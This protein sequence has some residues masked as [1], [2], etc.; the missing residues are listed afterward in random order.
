MLQTQQR[1]VNDKTN[2]QQ[3]KLPNLAGNRFHDFVLKTLTLFSGAD[4]NII[5][6]QT[7]Y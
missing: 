1:V 7:L 2:K 4:Y 6:S 5:Y 3:L